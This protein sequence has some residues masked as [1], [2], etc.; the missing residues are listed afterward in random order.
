MS[1]APGTAGPPR[2]AGLFI[3][4]SIDALTK[5]TEEGSGPRLRRVLGP[6]ALVAIGLGNMVGA[7]I[8]ATI[9]TGVH[10]L[11]GPAVIVSF[12]IAAVV[13]ALAALCYAEISSM[14]PLAGSAYTYTYATVGELI[15]WIIGWNLIWE[16]GMAAAPV[17]G[18]LSANL[19]NIF[20]TWGMHLPLWASS[21]FN[22]SAHTYF[23]VIAAVSVLA[24]SVL[25][26]IGI[27]ESAGTN[28]IL[29]ILKMG[30]LAL[31]II[32]GLPF[33]NPANW[34]PFV[35]F[36]WR[37][38]GAMCLQ[39]IP[40]C[41]IIP[42]AFSVF[43]AF[44]GFDAVTT[45]AEEAKRPQRDVPLGVMGALA[46]GAFFYIAI[47]IVLTGMVPFSKVDPGSP[48]PS[49]LES[50]HMA[51][52]A[53]I[54]V[55]GALIGTSSVILTSLLGQSRIFFVMAR[56]GL[57]PKAVATVHPRFQTPAAMT[58]TVGVV[59]ALVAGFV[60]LPDSLNLVN[61]GTLSAFTLVSVGVLV[62]RYTQPDRPRGFKAPFVPLVP[63]LAAVFAVFLA[64]LG[65]QP[66]TLEAFGIW[67]VVGVVIY[68]AYGYRNSEERK[69]ALKNQ[70]R[71]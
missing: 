60:P 57:L 71:R 25:L 13:S 9:G 63:V 14:V 35:P 48:L 49:A 15:A 31:F 68:F 7:G 41:G 2:R 21:A 27:R 28:S 10:D 56:D 6:W 34:H 59:V 65:A 3:T 70:D 43:F 4:R 37:S 47:A 5:E 69:A 36:G 22:P 11:A 1:T 20:G 62:L 55:V 46:L 58:M 32:I 8:F 51:Q 64:F 23:D 38:A 29:V 50:V 54:P 16:Y 12:I 52:W 30:V 67:L 61:L 19:Q 17:A 42:A 45:A 26:T 24:F 39:G 40:A 53:W 33:I 66:L 18:T 44:I